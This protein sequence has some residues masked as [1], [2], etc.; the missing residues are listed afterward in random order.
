MSLVAGISLLG[1]SPASVFD[2][3]AHDL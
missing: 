3:L 1:S 2:K